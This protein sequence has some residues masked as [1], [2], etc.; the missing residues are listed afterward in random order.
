MSAAEVTLAVA[1]TGAMA[2][3]HVRRFRQFA[4]VRIG[5]CYDRRRA[6]AREFAFTHGIPAFYDSMQDLLRERVPDAVSV[7]VAD[8]EHFPVGQAVLDAQTPLFMEKPLTAQAEET[9]AFE[10]YVDRSGAMRPGAAYRHGSLSPAST[11][12]P[13]VCNFSKLN[14]PAIW[15]AVQLLRSG[16]FGRVHRLRLSYF[17]SWIVSTVWGEWWRNPRWLWRI[18]SSHAGGGALRD[19]GSH[20]FYLALLIAGPGKLDQ[21]SVEC[22][23]LRSK[24]DTSGYSCDL[25]DTFTSTIVH[26]N[27]CHSFVN[28]SYAAPGHVNNVILEADCDGGGVRVELEQSKTEV[29]TAP[30]PGSPRCYRSAKVFSTYDEFL[31][32]LMSD[33]GRR[34]GNGQDGESAGVGDRP[35][36]P[37]RMQGPSLADGIAV[38]RL[39]EAGDAV[40]CT[41]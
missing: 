3:Y 27:G 35:I 11:R 30:N 25:N 24:A 26:A 23:A 6:R 9:D 5:A 40:L 33:R 16:R 7:A 2:A 41:Q 28:G 31:R 8:A 22:A 36:R 13:V 12:V 37:G 39:I 1:G 20:L 14:Y 19:L 4:N 21:S 29:T 15:S 38:Q 34:G 17:Q 18:S 10:G 32:M